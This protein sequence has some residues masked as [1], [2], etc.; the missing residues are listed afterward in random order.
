MKIQ[1]TRFVREAF[2]IQTAKQF[3]QV[4][5]GG[6]Y[7][8]ITGASGNVTAMVGDDEATPIPIGDVRIMPHEVEIGKDS[9]FLNIT[10][11]LTGDVVTVEIGYGVGLPF[12]LL[13]AKTNT[14]K[15]A[16]PAI[17]PQQIIPAGPGQINLPVPGDYRK[18]VVTLD[19]YAPGSFN[20]IFN[21]LNAGGQSMSVP[22]NIGAPPNWQVFYPDGSVAGGLGQNIALPGAGASAN[23]TYIIPLGGASILQITDQSA[24]V[25]VRVNGQFTNGDN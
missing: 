16:P 20:V 15:P 12:D 3:V 11:D 23:V 18:A 2:T 8:V 10:S 4:P 6:T 7:F 5:Y 22:S 21:L 25:T 14:V 17:I 19:E 24:T 1:K 9:R 13:L